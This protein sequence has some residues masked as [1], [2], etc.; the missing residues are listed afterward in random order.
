M[1]LQNGG[2]EYRCLRW[3]NELKVLKQEVSISEL[4][5]HDLARASS[6]SA[7]R[8]EFVDAHGLQGRWGRLKLCRRYET[9]A[10]LRSAIISTRWSSSTSRGAGNGSRL[11]VAMLRLSHCQ[12]ALFGNLGGGSGGGGRDPTS[13]AR[14]ECSDPAKHNNPTLDTYNTFSLHKASPF[15]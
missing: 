4:E 9:H 13:P 15:G 3:D 1:H 14:D 11:N 10:L 2:Q 5:G 7:S 12:T 8:G 6:R